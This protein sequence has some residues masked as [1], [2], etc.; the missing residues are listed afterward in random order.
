MAEGCYF[1]TLT[2]FFGRDN[3]FSLAATRVVVKVS[4]RVEVSAIV[5][6]GSL[7]PT[8]WASSAMAQLPPKSF[9]NE[10]ANNALTTDM[11]WRAL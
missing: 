9:N 4:A 6:G 1:G 3:E 7:A 5:A 8:S 11:M 2:R 10:S